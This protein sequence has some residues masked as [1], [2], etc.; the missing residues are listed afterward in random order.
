[1]SRMN[2]TAIAA[3]FAIFAIA[4]CE[5]APPAATQAEAP[6]PPPP[7]ST[8]TAFENARLIVGDGSVVENGV[9]VIDGNSIVAAG[10]AGA[11]AVPDGATVIDVAGQ[12]IMP[13]LYDAHVHMNETRDALLQDLRRR[14]YFGVAAA[15]T[16]GSDTGVLL[17]MRDEVIPGA[18]RYFSAGLGITSPEPGRNEVH[19][20]TTEAEARAAVQELAGQEVDFV[21]IWVDDRGQYEKLSPELY[22]A[23][24][25]EAHMHGLR[26]TGHIFDLEDAKGVIRAGI[27][28]FAHMVRD[29]EVDDEFIELAMQNPDLMIGPNLPVRGIVEDY[30]WLEPHLPAEEYA[31]IQ[32]ANV[33]D[34]TRQ[35]QFAPQIASLPRVVDAG[36]TIILGTDGNNPWEPHVQLEYMVDG[37]MSPMGTLIAVTRD[38]ADS[39]GL[40]AGILAAGK[41]A[42]FIVL[43][44]NPLDD[45]TNTRQ[46]D[47]VY[48]RGEE[49]DRSAYP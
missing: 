39:L 21:K 18:A 14:A 44:A 12:T 22:T 26:V 33:V 28:A 2:K 41:D 7:V 15:Q 47:A 24:I 10:A 49:V 23:V 31:A 36:V 35:E 16:L 1:M 4:G 27:D 46:I 32:E 45:I 19:W 48:L 11:V 43:N 8:A 9:L 40:N 38:S 25:D 5:Q 37:G 17:E 34:E 29:Q 42:D 6:A 20:V 3:A 30:S 13:A